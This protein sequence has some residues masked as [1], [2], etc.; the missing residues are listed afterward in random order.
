MLLRPLFA[1]I[2]KR[3]KII[4]TRRVAQAFCKFL[5]SEGPSENSNRNWFSIFALAIIVLQFLF[6]DN[7]MNKTILN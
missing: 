5:M 2:L 4:V 6:T 1:A 7:F 3:S